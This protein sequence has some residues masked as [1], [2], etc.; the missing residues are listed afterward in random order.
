[1]SY[2]ALFQGVAASKPTSWLSLPL[3]YLSPLSTNFGTLADGLGCFPLVPGACP[4]ET[5]S[6]E[7]YYGI[8]SLFEFGTPRRA[9]AQ[10]VLYL[11]NT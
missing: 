11:H 1:M 9:L 8:R 10:P 4:P 3:Y 7:T 2:Y 6:C 5:D